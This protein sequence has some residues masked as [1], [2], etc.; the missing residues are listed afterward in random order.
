MTLTRPRKEYPVIRDFSRLA[1][2]AGLLVLVA[3]TAAALWLPGPSASA[4]QD[5]RYFSDTGFRIDDDQIWDYFTKRGRTRTFGLPISR[6]FEF[7]GAPTQF[8]QR[9]VVQAGR[10]G[11][12]TLNLL[13]DGLLPY[14]TINGSTFPGVDPEVVGKSPRP[15]S[16]GYDAAVVAFIREN[17]P[18]QFQSQPVKFY[19]TFA[20][21]VTLADAFPDGNGNA[22]LLPLLNLELWGQPTSKPTPDPNNGSFIYQRFQRGVMHYDAGCTCTQGLLL[23]DALKAVITGEN[24]P[25]DLAA[26]AATSPLYLQYDPDGHTGPLRP[27]DLPDSD[28][29]NAFRPSLDTTPAAPRPVAQ[30]QPAAKPAASPTPPAATATPSGPPA[31]DPKSLLV[32]ENEAGRDAKTGDTKDGSDS[33]QIWASARFEREDTN[34]NRHSGP[35]VVYS[36]AI[37]A[38]DVDTARQIFAQEASQNEKFPEAKNKVGGRFPFNTE[39]DED[40]GEEAK[41]QSACTASKCVEA[42]EMLH[43]RIVFRVGKMVGVIYTYGLDDPEGNTQAFTRQFAQLMVKRMRD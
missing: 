3:L 37:I 2:F 15:G 1:R 42:D 41:G 7:M 19:D 33:R 21:T 14:T 23:A 40:V 43:R 28:L 8:F 32:K 6:T 34:K 16:P 29:S 4:Q 38:R 36:R 30:T 27:A 11:I 26:Q 25:D 31:G 13:D 12:R 24:L 18:N 39:G 10:G 5:E 20:G 9:Q 17:A 22:D 35:I